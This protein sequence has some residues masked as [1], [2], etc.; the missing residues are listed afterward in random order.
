MLL[1][2]EIGVQSAL[3]LIPSVKRSWDDYPLLS[4]KQ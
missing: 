1:F 4:L 2:P 3:S